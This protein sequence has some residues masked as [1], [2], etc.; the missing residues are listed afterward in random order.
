MW[1]SHV[2][3]STAFIILAVILA[4]GFVYG[5]GSG[6]RSAKKRV[7][8]QDAVIADLGMSIK[9]LKKER[10]L[11]SKEHDAI[12]E[13]LKQEQDL[14]AKRLLEQ[15]AAIKRIEQERDF[16]EQLMRDLLNETVD[17]KLVQAKIALLV[18]A[19]GAGEMADEFADAAKAGFS[20]LSGMLTR[21]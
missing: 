2:A 1:L 12:I 18:A 8:E 16:A 3:V 13:S 7:A 17:K 5:I 4:V 20:R 11:A 9:N 15:D 21:S 19:K 10:D 14:A 6:G